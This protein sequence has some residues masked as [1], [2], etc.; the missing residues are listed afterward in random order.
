MAFDLKWLSGLISL[1]TRGDRVRPIGVEFVM[2]TRIILV[3][4]LAVFA[5]Y[6]TPAEACSCAGPDAPCSQYWRVSAVFAGRVE[7]IRPTSGEAGN[8]AVRFA[9]ERRG[10]GVTTDT[11]VVESPAQNGVNCGYTFQPGE[12]YVVY[13]FETPDR[14]LV[15]HMCAGNKRF[16]DAAADL[17]FLDEVTGPPRGVRVFGQ[18]R[19]VDDD[20]MSFSRRDNGG[21]ADA[22]VRVVGEQV[23]REAITTQSGEYDFRDLPPGTYQVAVTPPPGLA[24]PGPPLPRAQHY[25]PPRPFTLTNP[26]QCMQLRAWLHT[27]SRITGVLRNTDGSPADEEEIDLIATSSATRSDKQIPHVSVRTGSDGR[28]TFAFIA[29]GTYL[30]GMNLKNPPPASQLDRRS[31]HPGVR[32]PRQA[33]VVT[34][35]EG[36]RLELT[37]FQLLEWPRERRM[38]GIVVWTD[39]TPAPDASLSLMAAANERVTLDAEGRFTLTLPY[40]ARFSLVAEGTRVINGRRVGGSSPYMTIDRNDRDADIRVV[41]KPHP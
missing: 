30:V 15:T 35:R 22:R 5:L 28:F 7:D 1:T 14:K 36:G 2:M 6:A 4:L 10:R 8:L 39:G 9:V 31:Y 32:D 18:V 20:L 23:S 17:A 33:T 13:A 37:P 12:R 27:D 19:R 16:A 11:V 38:S 25:P 21:V 26:S 24:F 41:M 3:A 40:G 34:V 29:P